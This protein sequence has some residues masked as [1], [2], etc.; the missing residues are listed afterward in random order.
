MCQNCGT[1]QTA[2]QARDKKMECG[3]EACQ[4]VKAKFRP[5]LVWSQVEKSFT[6]R[7]VE[8]AKRREKDSACLS[9]QTAASRHAPSTP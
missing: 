6:C 1:M 5:K 8:G 3:E 2:E 7:M 4:A 9:E